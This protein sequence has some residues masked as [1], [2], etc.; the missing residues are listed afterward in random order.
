M[1]NTKLLTLYTWTTEKIHKSNE[2]FA[3]LVVEGIRAGETS[4]E[5]WDAQMQNHIVM[6]DCAL[7]AYCAQDLHERV[8]REFSHDS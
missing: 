5:D 8:F 6:E 2:W 7:R 4:L 3:P 1:N